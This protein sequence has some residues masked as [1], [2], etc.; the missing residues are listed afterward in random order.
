MNILVTGGFGFIG[1]TFDF[2]YA[3]DNS[4]INKELNWYPKINFNQGI[5][6]TID[7]YKNE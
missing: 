1:S 7:F 5:I 2:R 6:R 3:I 4:K